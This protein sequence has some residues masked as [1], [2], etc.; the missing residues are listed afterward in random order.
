MQGFESKV[1]KYCSII[2][3]KSDPNQNDIRQN[4]QFW[5]S[6]NKSII[7]LTNLFK[8]QQDFLKTNVNDILNSSIL[9]NLVG[10][11]KSLM[12]DLRS[13]QIRDTC[14]FLSNLSSILGDHSKSFLSIFTSFLKLHNIIITTFF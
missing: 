8:Q 5:E 7:E 9:R 2:L 13:Q 4:D 11:I 3:H 14:L 6:R 10:P 1:E 12:S